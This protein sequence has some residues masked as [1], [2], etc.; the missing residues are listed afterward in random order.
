MEDHDSILA[1]EQAL[2]NVDSDASD[3]E[4]NGVDMGSESR[5]V[6]ENS[7]LEMNGYP[8]TDK[9]FVDIVRRFVMEKRIKTNSLQ[10]SV[11]GSDDNS[12]VASFSTE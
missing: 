9:A 2:D 5:S 6:V 11:S 3:S 10:P 1:I 4:V 8:P 7:D 12:S